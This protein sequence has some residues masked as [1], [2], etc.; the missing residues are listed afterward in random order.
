LLLEAASARGA[1]YP[2]RQPTTVL[3][4]AGKSNVARP[5]CPAFDGSDDFVCVGGPDERLLL[6]VVAG[7]VAGDGCLE[8]TTEWKRPR[9]NDVRI[10]ARLPQKER[11]EIFW[12]DL[13][14]WFL[15]LSNSLFVEASARQPGVAET[16]RRCL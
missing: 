7:E 9:L 8:V 5:A 15:P 10:H 13:L 11:A 4:V 16:L 14:N 6:A 1:H 3:G 2:A 12:A